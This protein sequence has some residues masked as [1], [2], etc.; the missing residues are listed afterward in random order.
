MRTLAFSDRLA[1]NVPWFR[2]PCKC[3]PEQGSSNECDSTNPHRRNTTVCLST[4][5]F[6]CTAKATVGDSVFA[7]L[8]SSLQS[9]IAEMVAGT[10]HEEYEADSFCAVSRESARSIAVRRS[11]FE[12]R[13]LKKPHWN[14]LLSERNIRMSITNN[15]KILSYAGSCLSSLTRTQFTN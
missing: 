9:A 10:L 15:V 2:M 13:N 4:V 1:N 8:L 14:R 11:N 3:C 7:E 5:R 6:F 12:D